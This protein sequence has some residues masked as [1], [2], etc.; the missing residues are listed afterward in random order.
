MERIDLLLEKYFTGTSSLAEEA[1]LRNYFKNKNIEPKHETY[2]PLFESFA[3]EQQIR[4]TEKLPSFDEKPQQR[5]SIKQ[6][7]LAGIVAAS[8]TLILITQTPWK[9]ASTAHSDYAIVM[10][11]RID[12]PEFAQQYAT[13]KMEKINSKLERSLKPVK[14]IERVNRSLTPLRRFHEFNQSDLFPTE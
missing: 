5:F 13:E 8:L 12:D 9:Q 2:K 14:C 1:E 6:W 7:Y 3:H 10:G 4:F 11:K